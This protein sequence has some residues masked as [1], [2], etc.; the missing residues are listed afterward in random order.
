MLTATDREMNDK[1]E[2]GFKGATSSG[3]EQI[4]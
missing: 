3:F 2:T 1:I 4:T